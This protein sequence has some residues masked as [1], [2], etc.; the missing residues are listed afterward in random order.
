MA[1]T[2]EFRPSAESDIAVI[3]DHL[4]QSHLDFGHDTASAVSLAS[5]RI[6]SI[7]QNRQRI[8]IAPE[9]GGRIFSNNRTYRHLTIERTIYWFTLDEV[10]QII[11]IEAIFH[12]GQDHLQHMLARLTGKER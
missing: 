9:R 4:V 2:V 5:G 12:G 11:Q 8:A 6:N 1:W 10:S 3:F 7:V